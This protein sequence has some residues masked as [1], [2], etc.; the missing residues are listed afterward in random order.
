MKRKSPERAPESTIHWHS[1]SSDK[2]LEM[3]RTERARGL[4]GAE[5]ERRLQKFGPN[6]LPKAKRTPVWLRFLLQFHNILIYV[7]LASAAGALFV[8]DRVDAAA[9]LAVTV[10]N[11]IIGFMQE[12]KAEDALEAIRDML[13]LSASVLRDGRRESMPAAG[14]APGDIVFL[15]AG[16]KAPAD[17]RLLEVKSLAMD[18]SALTGESVPSEKSQA[19]VP[20]NAPLGDRLCMAFAGTLATRGQ[21]TGAVVATGASTELGRI[22]AL[23]NRVGVPETPLQRRL[24]RFGRWL[25]AFILALAAAVYGFGVLVRGLSFEE[26]F[27]AMVG[28]AVAAIPEGLPAV[29]TI[30]L[31]AGVARMARRKAIV[32]YLP[33]VETLGSV[34]TIC[35]DKTG[36]LTRNEMTVNGVI[37]ATRE[38]TLDEEAGDGF[39]LDGL[40]VGILDYPGLLEI[41][42]AGLLCND[43]E[44][45]EDNGA[46]RA[47]GDPTEIALLGL[48]RRV[49]LD[50]RETRWEH[51]RLDAIPFESERRY[52]ASLHLG[53]LGERLIYLKG[54]PEAVLEKCEMQREEG[55]MVPLRQHYWR[56]RLQDMA[57][58]GRRVLALAM[59]R[60]PSSLDTLGPEQMEEGFA[61]L[62]LCG[63][64]DPPRMEA[65][66]AVDEC[67][68]AGIRVKMITGDHAETAR[69][70]A[71]MLGIDASRVMTGAEIEALPE[72]E[73]IAAARQSEVFA[74][75]SPEHKLRLVEALQAD[76]GVVAMTG[77]GVNDAPAL[78]RADIGVAMGL[79]GSEAA[80]E[81]AVMVLADDNFA[82]IVHA[83]EEGRTVYD[84]LKKAIV[85]TLPT[86]FGQAGAIMAGILLGQ[87]LPI[88][89]VQILWV[90][91]VTAVTLS[92]SFSFEPPE[93]DIMMR[94]PRDP[95]EP[96]L[97]GFLIWRVLFVSL[98]LVGGALGLFLHELHAGAAL[99]SARTAAVNAL[100]AGEIAYLFNSRFI[101]AS[102]LTP[103][104]LAGAPYAWLAIA[105][106]VALQLLLTYAPFM[107]RAFGTAALDAE[108]WRRIGAFGLLL[109]LAVEL[110]KLVARAV[111]RWRARYLPRRAQGKARGIDREGLAAYAWLSIAA[112][113]LTIGLKV[114]AWRLTGSV[115]LLSD[116]MESLV[117]LAAAVMALSMLILA[118]KPPDDEHHFG[119]GKAEYFSS[120]LEGALI[121][122]AA[123]GIGLAGFERLLHPRPLESLDL[124]LAISALAALVNL[125]VALIL[126]RAGR[127]HDSIALEADAKHLL[128]DVWTSAGVLLGLGAAALTGWQIL[129]PVVALLVALNIVWTGI[130]LVRRSIAGL[131]DAT[132]PAA[133]NARIDAILD[134]YRA[135]G[136]QFHELRTRRSGAYRFLTVHVLAPGDMTIKAGHDRVERIEADIRAELGEIVVLAHL[137]PLE[138]PASY[139]HGDK[140]Q[141]DPGRLSLIRPHLSGE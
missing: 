24:T 13:S 130:N 61:M 1:L 76:G 11:A 81:A 108:A 140:G 124:G 6:S 5:A 86:S 96:L 40:V 19:P 4:S 77:D 25:T 7:L 72:R 101:H 121:L 8:G 118:A 117:N 42:R 125:G 59:K 83:V 128:T 68:E 141:T 107:Q 103:R 9:I 15:E 129:D 2:S 67:H 56:E 53:P 106:I 47:N 74:R 38:F 44:I 99:D 35:T 17:L 78:K 115:G 55:R 84:N 109:F 119:H 120:G 131:L 94:P 88:S 29:V 126:L 18:E 114:W 12:S 137:E 98:L 54:A 32:R 71:G 85:F 34:T 16:D 69:A 10:I 89:P 37:D 21:A 127:R 41:V 92:L 60:A 113:V 43:A 122:V 116:A 31:A 50:Y 82:T 36:T 63:M 70:V 134:R 52:M 45:V 64:I 57:A 123:A 93:P 138:D 23:T 22:N 104:A 80:K 79:R 30:T 49:G 95:G 112:A 105:V 20:P 14:L 48:G 51:S 27:M 132:L 66:R 73:L 39:R 136:L 46:R 90:N 100:I 139:R 33:A 91:L 75:T 102:A 28:I 97:G 3:L 135:Q 110:E 26:M 111:L 133:E 62:G 58:S 65:M 87:T